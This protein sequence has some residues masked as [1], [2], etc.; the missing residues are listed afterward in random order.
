MN[1]KEQVAVT[2]A[3]RLTKHTAALMDMLRGDES[4][5]EYLR[6]VIERAMPKT[7]N[8]DADLSDCKGE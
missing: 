1:N 8:Q 2:V 3:I 7:N 5:S 6:K 4:R